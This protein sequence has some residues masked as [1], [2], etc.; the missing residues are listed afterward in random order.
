ML[1][2]TAEPRY[3]IQGGLHLIAK[4]FRYFK[5]LTLNTAIDY[6]ISQ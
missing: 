2:D 5:I 4:E 1:V 6:G 3:I